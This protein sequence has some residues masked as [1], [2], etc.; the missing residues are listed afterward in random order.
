M[1]QRER[2]IKRVVRNVL[3]NKSAYCLLCFYTSQEERP[4]A[5]SPV[6]SELPWTHTRGA[7]SSY[8]EE[9]KEPGNNFWIYFIRIYICINKSVF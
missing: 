6:I 7:V 8:G 3:V 1:V 4:V 9:V 5:P 2:K